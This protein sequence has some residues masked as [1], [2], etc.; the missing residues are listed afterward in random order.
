MYVVVLYKGIIVSE[1][2]AA[3]FFLSALKVQMAA[4]QYHGI[5]NPSLSLFPATLLHYFPSECIPSPLHVF[6]SSILFPLTQAFFKASESLLII[7]S[8]LSYSPTF[9]I[10]LLT[11]STSPYEFIV[12]PVFTLQFTLF[13][14]HLPSVRQLLLVSLP[15]TVTQL[16]SWSYFLST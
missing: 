9:H 5:P 14:P 3:A 11:L 7:S 2:L 13:H 8:P 10:I 15:A 4:H 6:S 16:Q 1:E 12:I